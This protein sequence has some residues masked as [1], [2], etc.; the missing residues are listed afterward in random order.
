MEAEF[1]KPRGYVRCMRDGMAFALKNFKSVVR[2]AWPAVVVM[3]LL[4]GVAHILLGR[5]FS[6]LLEG[7]LRS[8]AW[9]R[10]LASLA[11]MLGTCAVMAAVVSQ[12]RLI[13]PNDE[14]QWQLPL[15]RNARTLAR[16]FLRVLL[17]GLFFG[18]VGTILLLG[19]IMGVMALRNGLLQN[20]S[21]VAGM[22]LMSLVVVV[23]VVAWLFVSGCFLLVWGNY[24]Y[25]DGGLTSALKDSWRQ[26]NQLGRTTAVAFLVLVCGLVLGLVFSLPYTVL[27]NVEMSVASSA[28][29]GDILFLPGYFDFLMWLSVLLS[30]LGAAFGQMLLSYPMFFNWQS[31]TAQPQPQSPEELL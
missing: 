10:T 8:S 4:S 31:I 1:G 15:R 5:S 29:D 27:L 21:G 2:Y 11:T 19:C 14:G 3:V 22:L 12:Q 18:V 7:E 13:A 28:A 9:L 30:A 6:L 20:G 25:G 16:N 26:R 17:V 23:A 24:M